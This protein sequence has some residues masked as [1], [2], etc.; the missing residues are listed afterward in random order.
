MPGRLAIYDDSF[1]RVEA[2][3]IFNNVKNNIGHIKPTYNLAPTHL[4]PVLLNTKVYTY[5]HFGLI[6]S[7]AK[8]KKSININ[9]RSET[10]FEKKSFRD[11]FKSKRCLIP[12]NGFYEWE[13]VDKERFPYFVKPINEGCF[14]LAGLWAQWH[15]VIKNEKIISVALITTP[16]NE[17]I[18]KIH[19][20]MPV[21]LDQK[22]WK[23]WLDNNTSLEDL[24]K[25]FI[26]SSSTQ[27]KLNEVSSLVNSVKN[28]TLACIKPFKRE[29]IIKESLF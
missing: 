8:D 1:F 26:P 10:L 17:K 3:K 15:D 16:P 11:S 12:V 6:P 7:W 19:D 24:N 21:I 18:A 22:D 25:L 5:A 2:K 29:R 9:A 14:V 13:K 27:L 23:S 20:R 4:L 28:N